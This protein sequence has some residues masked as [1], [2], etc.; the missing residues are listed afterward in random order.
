MMFA[1]T[2]HLDEAIAEYNEAVR[3]K[4]DFAAARQGLQKALAR[5]AH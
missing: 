5:K 2:N 1:S 4:P 3:L